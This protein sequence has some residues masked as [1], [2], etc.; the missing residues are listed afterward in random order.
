[1]D[2]RIVI[3]ADTKEELNRLID[4]KIKEGYL[5]AGAMSEAEQNK[6]SQ[7]MTLAS[8]IDG[9]V[10]LASGIKLVA[11]IAF[12]IYFTFFLQPTF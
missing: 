6:L 1:M 4:E 2:Y 8:N 5:I 3:T 12:M 10:T 9:E 7:E 11:A